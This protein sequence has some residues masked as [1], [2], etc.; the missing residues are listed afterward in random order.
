MLS[1]VIRERSAQWDCTRCEWSLFT[2][3][4]RGARPPHEDV[5]LRFDSHNC[6]DYPERMLNASEYEHLDRGRKS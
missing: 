2:E 5:R 4:E 1:Y 3:H 6:A